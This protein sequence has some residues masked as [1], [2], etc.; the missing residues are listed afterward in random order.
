MLTLITLCIFIFCVVALGW[1]V[2][3]LESENG[4]LRREN[5]SMRDY[6]TR[7]SLIP[8]FVSRRLKLLTDS[9]EPKGYIDAERFSGELQELEMYLGFGGFSGQTRRER[10]EMRLFFEKFARK[11]EKT[12]DLPEND[13]SANTGGG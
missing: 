10:E 3:R 11:H 6:V 2:Y 9:I 12:E 1:H 4:I 8:E 13:L 5:E 7:S